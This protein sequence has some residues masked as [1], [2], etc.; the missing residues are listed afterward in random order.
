MKTAQ[1]VDVPSRQISQILTL[2]FVAHSHHG[3]DRIYS[4]GGRAERSTKVI[5]IE[6]VD[7]Q[8]HNGI[9]AI[10]SNGGRAEPTKEAFD[11]ISFVAERPTEPYLFISG[12]RA[13]PMKKANENR[14]F[15]AHVPLSLS[16]M[17]VRV[18]VPRFELG[19]STMPR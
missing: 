16:Q 14:F 5:G 8:V 3:I 11:S 2:S 19:A 12:G 17:L 15:M 4:N 9:D 7:A 13:E 1:M 10:C 18:D 6:F